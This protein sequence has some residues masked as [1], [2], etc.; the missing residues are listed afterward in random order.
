MKYLTL[1]NGIQNL[2]IIL[3]GLSLAFFTFRP[4][5]AL[6]ITCIDT[7]TK[8]IFL[9]TVVMEF[10]YEAAAGHPAISSSC[11]FDVINLWS[12]GG[13]EKINLIEQMRIGEGKVP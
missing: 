8:Q 5:A 4:P 1:S 6:K 2:I 13:V 11:H 12:V 9:Q 3:F 7:A 10:T